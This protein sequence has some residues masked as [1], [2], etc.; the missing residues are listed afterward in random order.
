MNK[1]ILLSLAVA[2]FIGIPAQKAT[3]Q[4]SI[5]AQAFAEVIAALTATET[6]QL[7]FGRFSPGGQGGQIYISPQGVRHASGTLALSG[8]T[9]NPASFYITG[10][11]GATFSITLPSGPAILTNVAKAKTMT[12]SGWESVPP[13]GIASGALEGGSL[14]VNVGA[15]L[16]VGSVNDNPVGIYAGTYSIIFAYN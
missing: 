1:L 11:N 8:G 9:F 6:S 14:A 12:V 10:E 4:A 5:T 13:A 2:L 7:N 3:A 15:T 16:T